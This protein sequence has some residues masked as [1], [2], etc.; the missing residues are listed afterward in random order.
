[1]AAATAPP[2][3]PLHRGRR[4]LFRLA[5][6]AAVAVALYFGQRLLP[7]KSLPVRVV[8]SAVGPVRDVVSSSSAGEVTPKV[9][10]LVRG[11]ISGRILAVHGERGSRV[12]RGEPL[13]TIDPTDLDARVRQAQAALDASIAQRAQSAARLKTLKMQAQ[14]AQLL[15]Q[16]GAGTKQL[17]DDADA[18]VAEAE[19]AIRTA[20]SQRAQ[21]FAAWQIATVQRSRAGLLAPF[22][23]VLTEISVSVGDSLTPAA[24]VVQIM[25]DSRLHVDAM[26]DEAD[27]A[28]VRVGEAAELRLDALPER[29]FLGQ[30]VRVDPMIKRDLKGARTLTVE[31][32]VAG[33]EAARAA[34]LKPGMSANVDIIVAEKP[35][36]LAVPSNVIVGRGVSRFVYVVEP[37]GSGH[38]LRKQPIVVGLSNWDRSEVLSG[39]TADAL[40]VSSLNEKGLEDGVLVSPTEQP[41][42]PAG[43]SR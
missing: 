41:P 4:L 20:E 28:R 27:A 35:Q 8:R 38:R 24:P 25:D 10:A 13:V 42:L 17:S 33:V 3:A 19:I 16:R 11:E 36:V 39:L 22:D 14:R 6:V 1:V 43:S 12:K 23:G 2:P 15:A 40:V 7:R 9:L 32:E 30:V 21:A 31:V 26:V 5:I 37:S 18:A 29:T 34:G